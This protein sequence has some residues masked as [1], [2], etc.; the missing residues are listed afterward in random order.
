MLERVDQAW[1]DMLTALG[2]S[3]PAEEGAHVQGKKEVAARSWLARAAALALCAR[4]SGA[5]SGVAISR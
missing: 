4:D 1:D 5:S 2:E 3:V